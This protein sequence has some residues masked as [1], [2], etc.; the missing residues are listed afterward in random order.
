MKRDFM[1]N[2]ICYNHRLYRRGATLVA[3][4]ESQ[5][6]SS[7]TKVAPPQLARN[8]RTQHAN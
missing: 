4:M 3:Q 6:A 2:M 1:E 7:A 8:E 5:S